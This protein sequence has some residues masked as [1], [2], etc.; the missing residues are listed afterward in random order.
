MATGSIDEVVYVLVIARACGVREQQ[1][2]RR[3]GAGKGG[4]GSRP[5]SCLNRQF[6]SHSHN[7]LTLVRIRDT[8]PWGM[9]HELGAFLDIFD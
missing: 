4:G 3:W 6:L 9:T 8:Y 7:H 1:Q 5:R 2:Q